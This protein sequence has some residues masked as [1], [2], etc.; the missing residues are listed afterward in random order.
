MIT[1]CDNKNVSIKLMRRKR[2]KSCILAK[3]N[4][5]KIGYVVLKVMSRAPSVTE[6]LPA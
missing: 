3:S 6:L 1:M 4:D 5:M 2:S